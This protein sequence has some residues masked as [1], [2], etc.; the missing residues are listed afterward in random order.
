MGLSGMYGRTS[1]DEGVATI[2]RAI[3]RGVTLLDTG[4]LH[5]Q[6]HN[7]MLVRR[8]IGGRRDGCSSRWSPAPRAAPTAPGSTSTPPRCRRY[9]SDP[10]A[11]HTSLRRRNHSVHGGL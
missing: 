5:G 4:D 6:G 9:A 3:E 1:D 2:Q 11:I 10:S 8:A 7:E